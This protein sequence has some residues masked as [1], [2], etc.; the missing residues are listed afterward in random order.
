MRFFSLLTA[1]L[2]VVSLYFV[3]IERERL[4]AFAQGGAAPDE[5]AQSL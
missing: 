5:A 3:V 2:V 1:V 4:V